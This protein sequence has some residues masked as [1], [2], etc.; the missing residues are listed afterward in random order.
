MDRGAIATWTAGIDAGTV[1]T[2]SG[3]LIGVPYSRGSRFEGDG[4]P[5]TNA[6][7]LLAAGQALC[8]TMALAERLTAAGHPANA[9]RTE[10][11]VHLVRPGR[12]WMVSAIRL[13]CTATVPG[14]TD[15]EFLALAHEAR[16]QSPIAQALRADVSLTVSLEGTR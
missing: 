2:D 10:A 3:A 4:P 14:I 7:E 5:G 9:L 6:E 16:M 1:T 15:S 13:H 11:R 8:F 12:H